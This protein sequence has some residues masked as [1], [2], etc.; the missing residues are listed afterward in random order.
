MDATMDV[1]VNKEL[2][3]GE[4]HKRAEIADQHIERHLRSDKGL[5]FVTKNASR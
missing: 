4:E 5:I 2:N 3:W 1:S